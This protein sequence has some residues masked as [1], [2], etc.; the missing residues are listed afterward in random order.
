MNADRVVRLL[1]KMGMHPL[2]LVEVQKELPI[3]LCSYA[4]TELGKATL[5]H[6]VGKC[7]EQL[8]RGENAGIAISMLASLVEAVASSALDA[9]S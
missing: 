2:A 8:Q 6:Y 4:E 7:I 9:V 1:W 3:V 5:A